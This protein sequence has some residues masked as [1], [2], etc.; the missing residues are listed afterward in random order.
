MIRS[1]TGYGRGRAQ[2][3]EIAFS[4]EIEQTIGD[5]D[6]D[7]AVVD[8][9]DEHQGHE[10]PGVEHQQIARRVVLQLHDPPVT[11]TVRQLDHVAFGTQPVNHRSRVDKVAVGVVGKRR[12]AD[13]VE[14]T[15]RHHQDQLDAVQMTCE[16]GPGVPA[17][18]RE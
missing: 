3:G 7:H 5:F 13:P 16:G 6:T 12:P 14:R 4:V 11:M 8:L 18:A 17:N 1:M 10:R 9:R 15:I 2:V